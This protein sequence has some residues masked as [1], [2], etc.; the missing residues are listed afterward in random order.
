VYI[1]IKNTLYRVQYSKTQA[2]T[3]T[4][5]KT[6]LYID[7]VL[8]DTKYCV[9]ILLLSLFILFCECKWMTNVPT[10]IIYMC[11]KH[12]NKKANNS[13]CMKKT[14]V[15]TQKWKITLLTLNLF[16]K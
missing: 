6:N 1:Q 16:Y 13:T 12:T 8:K 9:Y 15:I 3:V 10:T 5:L 4:N 7:F 14:P 11:I 2:Y